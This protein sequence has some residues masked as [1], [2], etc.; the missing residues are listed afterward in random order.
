[1]GNIS[2]QTSKALLKESET[3]VVTAERYQTL[4]EDI[5][6]PNEYTRY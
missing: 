6:I 4:S 2:C 3:A 1:M 5:E